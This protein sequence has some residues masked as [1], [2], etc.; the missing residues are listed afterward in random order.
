MDITLRREG[1]VALLT[2]D[3]GEN[4]VNVDS[5]ALLNARLD[6]VERLDGPLALVLRGTGKYFCNGMDLSR[7]EAL[8]PEFRDTLEVLNRLIGRLLVFPAYTVAAVNGHTFAAGAMLSCGF[9][10]QVMREDRGYWCLNEA[11][12]GITVNDTAWSLVSHRLPW[13]T[14]TAAIMT[15]RRFSGPEA[16]AA[17]IVQ[18]VVGEDEVT[19]HALEVAERYAALDRATLAG[20][21]RLIHGAQAARLGFS[22]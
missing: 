4:R 13:A 8:S 10:Y 12:L 2:W 19:E 7:F 14:A 21:K 17:G 20:H 5:L 16:L 22:F 11:E 6:E 18:A 15:A 1:P 9:D 3:D